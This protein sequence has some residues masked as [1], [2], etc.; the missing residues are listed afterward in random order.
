MPA[1]SCSSIAPDLSVPIAIEFSAV[2]NPTV[3]E[4]DRTIEESLSLTPLGARREEFARGLKKEDEV[5]VPK[6][7]ERCRVKKINKGERS[8]TVLLNGIPTVIGF[9]DVSWI[10]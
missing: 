8:L 10:G 9:D 7:R 5:Y 4:L 6:F 2:S 1:L 3:E